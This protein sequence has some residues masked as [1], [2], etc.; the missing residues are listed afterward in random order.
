MG[1]E[2]CCELG[3]KRHD[4][5]RG[6]RLEPPPAVRADSYRLPLERDVVHL[7]A[8]HFRGPGPG[9]EEGPDEGVSRRGRQG[10]LMP[11]IGGQRPRTL[12]QE[13]GVWYFE[14]PCL[15]PYAGR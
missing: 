11:G 3:P 2:D 5:S 6:Q 12:Q 15:A 1:P 8:E 14:P 4:P 13:S 9:Q 10:V 7:E